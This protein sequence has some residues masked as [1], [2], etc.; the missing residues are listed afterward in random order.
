MAPWSRAPCRHPVPGVR[1]HEPAADA[2]PL[3]CTRLLKQGLNVGR[4]VAHVV[5]ERRALGWVCLR[6][7][8]SFSALGPDLPCKLALL[9]SRR[10]AAFLK[11]V[12]PFQDARRWP[13]SPAGPR[14]RGVAGGEGRADRGRSCGGQV[15]SVGPLLA[16][17]P[18]AS[19]L[20]QRLR[21]SWGCPCPCVM[22]YAPS[23][24]ASAARMHAW[25]AL[26]SAC[27]SLMGPR[28]WLGAVTATAVDAVDAAGCTEL[29]YLARQPGTHV[30]SAGSALRE[31][32]PMRLNC[33]KAKRP[34]RANSIDVDAVQCFICSSSS[35]AELLVWVYREPSD[36]LADTHPK[37]Y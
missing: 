14:P 2:A 31:L 11:G 30:L 7:G 12:I 34:P 37:R 1:A 29:A 18:G 36:G 9:R 24:M 5:W 32:S 25:V 28:C 15:A 10:D 4:N 35:S 20:P 26:Q 16:R 27:P 19:A 3:Q 6:L 33:R 21:G 22:L 8:T 23:C 13:P 17:S